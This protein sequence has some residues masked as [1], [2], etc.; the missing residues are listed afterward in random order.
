MKDIFAD[1]I[2]NISAGDLDRTFQYR[3]PEELK[4]QVQVGTLVDVPFGKGRRIIKGYVVG[5]SEQEKIDAMRI[6]DIAAVPDD[7]TQIERKLIELAWWMQERYACTMLQALK[8]VLPIK[9]KIHKKKNRTIHLLLSMEDAGVLLGEYQKKHQTARTR[10]MAAL[11]ASDGQLD[12]A[13]TCR[14]LKLTAASIKPLTEQGIIQ[15]EEEQAVRIPML[16]R[17]HTKKEEPL[18]EEQSSVVAGIQR[19]LQTD[20]RPCLIHGITGSGKTRIYMELA[21]S[22]Q[23]QN[24]QTIVLIPEIAL[25]YQVVW[26]FRQRFGEQAA[27][28]HSKMSQGERWDAFEAARSGRITVMVGPRSALFTPFPDLGL[29]IMDEEHESSYISESTPRYRT[30]ET[31]KKRCELE[32]AQLVLGSAT[33]SLESYHKGLTGEYRLFRLTKRFGNG[34]LPEVQIVDMRQEFR[35]GNKSMLS[36]KL[37]E[38]LRIRLERNEQSLLFLNRRGYAGFVVCRG[39]GYVAKCP[40]CDVSLSQHKDGTLVCHYCGF[41]RDKLTRCPAC[42]S[43]YI[44][45]FRAGTQQIEELLKKRFQTARVLR[46]DLDTTRNKD[47]HA[48]IISKF[49]NGEADILI[50]TQMIIKGH[51]F[52]GVTLV[53]VLAADMSLHAASYQASE[54][55]FQMLVQAAGRAGRGNRPGT[56]LIQTYQPE[57]YSIEAAAAQDYV[58]FYEQEIL[59]RSL[60]HYPPAGSMLAISGSSEEAGYLETAMQYL[61]KYADFAARDTKTSVIGPADAAIAKLQDRYRK[62]IYIKNDNKEVLAR[63]MKLIQKYIEINHGFDTLQIQFDL[64]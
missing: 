64:Y 26:Q 29:V 62:V 23:R 44:G 15:I 32:N 52:P 19:E 27:V 51:D 22:M 48:K 6:K 34:R 59:F 60:L 7:P 18:S 14:E 61:K 42:G 57:H 45:G 58:S 33:P 53:G 11:L 10:L 43:E 54:R 1:I 12:Y 36:A 24:K 46:M 20:K 40:H 63:L 17:Y 56:A 8:T 41:V 28:L 30:A 37:E 39:C 47:G 21:D 13:S 35:E 4:H 31:A 9:K 49:A 50:G 55:T 5:I 2:V 16:P 38:E 25:T 3:I